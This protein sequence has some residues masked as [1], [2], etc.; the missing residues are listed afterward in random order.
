MIT[1]LPHNK[2]LHDIKE[3][4][5][6]VSGHKQNYFGGRLTAKQKT[7]RKYTPVKTN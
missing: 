7:K 5:E 2:Q 3:L 1:N 6:F 4:Y